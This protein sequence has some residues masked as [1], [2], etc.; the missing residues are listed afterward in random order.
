MYKSLKILWEFWFRKVGL[1]IKFVMDG[2]KYKTIK[3]IRN[4]M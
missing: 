2:N 3:N 4:K 1:W